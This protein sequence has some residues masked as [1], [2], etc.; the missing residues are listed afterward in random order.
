M[1][2]V[3]RNSRGIGLYSRRLHRGYLRPG[4]PEGL[5]ELLNRIA[6]ESGALFLMAVSMADGLGMRAAADAGALPGLRPLIAA[7]NKLELVNDKL[8]TCALAAELGI[9]VPITWEP[10]IAELDASIPGHLTY[11]CI[12]KWRD[13]E[14]T[15]APLAAHR[16][17]LLK[18]EY[19]A[20]ADALR[21]ALTRYRPAGLLPLVQS[22]CPGRGLGQMFLMKDGE[23]LLRFQH[24][25]IAEWPPDGGVSTVCRSLPPDAN[26][27]LM[28][29]SE[30]LLRRINWE[31]P[32]MVEYRFDSSTGKAALMEINGRFWGSLPLAYHAGVHFG[33]GTYCALG[34]N[35]R[36]EIKPYRAGLRCRYMIPN[37]RRLLA[38]VLRRKTLN[39]PQH[40][41]P[42]H[43]VLSFLADFF[44]SSSSYYVFCWRD[45]R[46]FFADML[47]A[48][49]AGL[50]R[51]VWLERDG[52]R[53]NR[54]KA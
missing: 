23:A 39:D 33:W 22:F 37:T 35:R 20:D 48:I 3:A 36:P 43:E 41:G 21:R 46:P 25:R 32:A 14:L 53:R 16:L 50:R 7:R 47:M 29:Q 42:L 30:A 12:L 17:P 1:H 38:V 19:V 31:G 44:R 11:P 18:S 24:E 9:P 51:M 6:R 49:M 8:C 13:P 10:T 4:S 28:A 26:A 52:L 45:P 15:A 34:L 40:R 2:G 5:I 54:R 27:S